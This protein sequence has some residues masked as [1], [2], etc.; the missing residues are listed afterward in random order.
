MVAVIG[1]FLTGRI[2]LFLNRNIPSVFTGG[3]F[4]DHPKNCEVLYNSSDA[5][6]LHPHPVSL[7]SM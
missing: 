4:I 6:L 1:S 5:P 2:A 7:F 3:Q